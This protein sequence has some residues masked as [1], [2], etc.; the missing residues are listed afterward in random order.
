MPGDPRLPG[1]WGAVVPNRSSAD[2]VRRLCLGEPMAGRWSILAVLFAV[3][4]TMGLQF[5]SVAAVAPLLTRDFGL[6]LAD[7][8]C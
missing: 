6:G 5:Q 7:S 8:V 1:A 3:R 4:A 2:V